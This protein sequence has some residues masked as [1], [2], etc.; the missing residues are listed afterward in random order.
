MSE[1]ME[2]SDGYFSAEGAAIK[3]CFEELK[4]RSRPIWC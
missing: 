3:R 4:D 2:F 1:I